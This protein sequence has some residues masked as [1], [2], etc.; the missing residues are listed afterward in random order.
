[1]ATAMRRLD[2]PYFE[3]TAPH[4]EGV[5][6]GGDGHAIAWQDAGARDGLPVVLPHGGP[7]GSMMPGLSRLADSRSVRTLQ[8]DQ[9]GCGRST[10][11][12]SLLANTLQSTIADME[13]LRE[14]LGIERWAVAGG[15]W[16]TTVALAYAQA[17]PQ[18][19]L[20]L[21]LCGTWLARERELR[22]W[23]GGVR[24]LFPELWHAFAA[25]V[26]EAERDDLRSAYCRRILGDDRALADE[27]AIRLHRYEEGFMHFEPPLSP[28]DPAR[29]AA[30]GRIFAHY[31]AHRFFLEEGQLLRDAPRIAHLPVLLITGRYDSCTPPDNAFDLAQRLPR[32]R[33]KIVS[34][35]GHYPTEPVLA[36][37]S[38][39][40][41]AE[42]V[43]WVR[44]GL[45]Q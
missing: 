33:L 29:G 22:W 42:F 35:A 32:A 45:A 3:L 17:H 11:R 24:T 20:G 44:E 38:V 19:C 13:R 41:F 28:P 43:H 31:A 23:F 7:G 18:R 15:S 21:Y 39:Q 6:E 9:R 16:G 4:A 8:F 25:A 37:A 30:Y 5:L 14:H 2:D 12:G 10:P 1:M 36:R 26:P 40:A 34:G 27:F